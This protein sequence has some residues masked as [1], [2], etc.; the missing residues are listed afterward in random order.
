V[1]ANGKKSGRFQVLLFDLD[2]TL[3]DTWGQLVAP[4]AREA[5]AAMI[6]AGLDAD[7]EACVRERERL[8]LAFPGQDVYQLLA[9]RFRLRAGAEAD[10]VVAAGD[11]A[12]FNRQVAPDIR[13]FDRVPA[14][15]ADLSADYALHL[16]TSGHP[17]TQTQKVAHLGIGA[18]FRSIH[19]VDSRAGE[20]KGAVFEALLS[21]A[22]CP[23]ARFMS[24][25]DR[26]DREIREAKALGMQTCHVHRGEFS[27]LHPRDPL[28]QPDY[29]IRH[30]NQLTQI[31]NQPPNP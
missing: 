25:G 16:V 17:A 15:L 6:A 19:L 12:Y 5:C 23:A 29:R 22:A 31:L 26:L 20:T 28:E 24:I 21:A 3:M 1:I 18:Y 10:K 14:L 27:H 13:P 4:A 11:D 7:L 9:E 8:F 30:I 2:D